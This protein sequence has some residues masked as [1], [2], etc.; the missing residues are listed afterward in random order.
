M[1]SPHERARRMHQPDKGD[2]YVLSCGSQPGQG[3]MRHTSAQYFWEKTV[4]SARRRCSGHV[5]AGSLM[6]MGSRR[7]TRIGRAGQFGSQNVPRTRA[8]NAR[9]DV[10]GRGNESASNAAQPLRTQIADCP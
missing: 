2:V 7:V 10:K 4:N 5:A 6:K 1:L 9:R 3:S 8:P